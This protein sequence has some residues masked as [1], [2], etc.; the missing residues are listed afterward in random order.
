MVRGGPVNFR[1]GQNIF[2]TY[3]EGLLQW[4]GYTRA[5]ARGVRRAGKL[6]HG[7]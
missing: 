2:Q 6:F 3:T 1:M 5:L 7:P 4:V